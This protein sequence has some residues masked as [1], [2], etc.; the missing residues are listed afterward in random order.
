[1]KQ[2]DSLI[3][4]SGRH[5]VSDRV[6]IGLAVTLLALTIGLS[7]PS[8]PIG[9]GWNDPDS[10]LRLVEIRDFLSGAGW[11]DLT[12]AR[13]GPNGVVMHWSRLADLPVA[14]LILLA[15]P[16][17]GRAGAEYF[18][19]SLWPPLL[20]IP[21]GLGIAATAYR[22]GGLRA[23][24]ISLALVYL[25][26]M[27][28][29]LFVPG[30][31]DHH[32]LQAAALSLALAGLVRAD[33]SAGW[34]A[35]AGGAAAFSLAVGLEMLAALVAAAGCLT[36]MWV[37]EGERWRPGLV[38]FAGSFA[39]AVVA[40]TIIA[41]APERWA[42]TVC[43]AISPAYALLGGTGGA[44]VAIAAT[45][46]RS[47]AE[48]GAAGLLLR[49]GSALGTGCLLVT[50]AALTYPDCLAGPYGQVDPRLYPIFL[51][52]VTEAQSAWQI[53]TRDPLGALGDYMASVLAL[54]LSGYVLVTRRR[55]LPPAAVLLMV[56]LAATF[57]VGAV[58]VRGMAAAQI[59]GAVIGG[60]VA[61]HLA[62]A[63][64]GR[65]DLAAVAL[66]L[67]F[68]PLAPLLWLLIGL[69]GTDDTGESAAAD[70][71]MTDC[72]QTFAEA[73]AGRSPGLVASTTNFGSFLLLATPHRVL[74]AP[75]H[76][77][78]DGLV[79]AHGII[80]GVPDR[81]ALDAAGVV[82]V[83]VCGADDEM[84]VYRATAPEGLFVQLDAGI[85]PDWLEPIAESGAGKV[86][87]VLPPEDATGS[88]PPLKLRPT[89]SPTSETSPSRPPRVRSAAI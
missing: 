54:G 80:T 64:R 52:H 48:D 85:R 50:L 18:A 15:D 77:N 9:P 46:V 82:Y 36:L 79:T 5:T 22:L 12:Q 51:D 4:G 39:I 84:G 88:L 76:R 3:L 32:N 31:I 68:L 21:F 33:R 59:V 78:T 1:M 41:V 26:P 8:P 44:A 7:A 73:L 62:E 2:S 45:L 57:A 30:R 70:A 63:T 71:G 24:L 11:F 27:V 56:L 67:S 38:A 40:F 25:S 28:A 14:A 72:R 10:M 19:V 69:A 75:Y 20:F 29:G 60:A 86:F 43:D 83:A 17:L 37:I 58:Q 66:R 49:A 65:T 35:L 42:M 87:R 74:A 61:A 89:L 16:I 53:L 47:R 81:N 6:W 23:A 55:D 34:S 13:M